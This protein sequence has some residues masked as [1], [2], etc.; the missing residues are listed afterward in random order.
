MFNKEYPKSCTMFEVGF[1]NS[2]IT[3]QRP[4]QVLFANN[5]NQIYLGGGSWI[6]SEAG[7]FSIWYVDRYIS[8]FRLLT[9]FR[10]SVYV[11]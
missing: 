9:G 7:M 2:V 1:E 3:S 6:H 5:S 10:G 4:S 11:L 8:K